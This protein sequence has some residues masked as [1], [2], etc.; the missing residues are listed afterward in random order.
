[1]RYVLAIAAACLAVSAGFA[2]S[3]YLYGS[4]VES[5]RQQ[6]RAAAAAGKLPKEFEGVDLESVTPDWFDLRMSA[7]DE[8]RLKIAVMISHLWFVWVPMVFAICLGA[9]YFYGPK[10]PRST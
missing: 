3:R 5:F 1:M 10:G 8:L 9:A 2:L 7:R 4:F 6:L